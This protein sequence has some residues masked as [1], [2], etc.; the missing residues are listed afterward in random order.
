VRVTRQGSVELPPAAG[1]LRITSGPAEGAYFELAEVPAAIG[2]DAGCTVQL[3]AVEGVA[4]Q[5]A[6]L[7]WRDG[8]PMLH[9]IADGYE[10]RVNGKTIDWASLDVGYVVE[11][12]P[13]TMR[14]EAPALPADV[15]REEPDAHRAGA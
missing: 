1:V 8:K 13:V 7:W 9:H 11:I 12:G 10:T 14:F 15:S 4:G 6:R 3:A 5:H 2:S